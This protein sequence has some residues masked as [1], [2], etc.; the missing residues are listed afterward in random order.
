MSNKSTLS[1]PSTVT[2]N[3]NLIWRPYWQVSVICH[4]LSKAAVN[5]C[6]KNK[7]NLTLT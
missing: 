1:V 7:P 6:W 3:F 5:Y 4:L 2:H